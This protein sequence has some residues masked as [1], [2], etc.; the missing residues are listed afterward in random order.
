MSLRTLR[1][2]AFQGTLKMLF[3]KY[4]AGLSDPSGW[5]C[6][7]PLQSSAASMKLSEIAS[8]LGARL[9]NG[10]PDTEITGVAGI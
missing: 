5:F 7:P 10:F 1:L 3:S 6:F 8:T 2:R 4:L 9:E